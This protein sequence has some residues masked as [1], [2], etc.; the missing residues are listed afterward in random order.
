MVY[1]KH[2]GS[3]N[4]KGY[5]RTVRLVYS[6]R[7]NHCT[8]RDMNAL[9]AYV[10]AVA[11]ARLSQPDVAASLADDTPAPTVQAAIDEAATLRARLADATEQF[12]AGNITAATLGQIEAR[13]RPAISDAERRARRA[14][15]PTVAADVATASDPAAAWDALTVEQRREVLRSMLVVVVNSIP[16]EERGRRGFN[17]DYVQIDWRS[18]S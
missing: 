17:P 12:V 3:L 15:L 2:G 7:H 8:V 16:V 18:A 11:L 14:G 10:T 5:M 9:D 13:L 4:N 6:C 1:A